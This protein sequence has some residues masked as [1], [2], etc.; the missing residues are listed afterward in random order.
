M[1]EKS[2][3]KD[4]ETRIGRVT[5]EIEVL[6]KQNRKLSSRV[7][8]LQRETPPASAMS[9]SAQKTWEGEKQ[10]L[11]DLVERLVETLESLL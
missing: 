7:K 11:R 4:L 6:R 1:T 5:E 9:G 8:R 3:W 10:E 2:S